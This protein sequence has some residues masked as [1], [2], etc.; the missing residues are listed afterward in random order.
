MRGRDDHDRMIPMVNVVFLLLAFFLI[1]GTLR[2]SDGLN[3]EPPE[4]ATSGA[5]ERDNPVLSIAADGAL[6]LNGETIAKDSAAQAAIR[7]LSETPTSELYIKASRDT[8]VSVILP[9]MR[10]LSE[11]GIATIRLIAIKKSSED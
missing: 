5:L 6:Y 7:L 10:T 2:V 11:Q 1:A 4:M 3:I 9:L 8:P